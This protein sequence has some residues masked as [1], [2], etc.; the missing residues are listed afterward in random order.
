MVCPLGSV[1]ADTPTLPE[2][3]TE[4]KNGVRCPRPARQVATRAYPASGRGRTDL[5]SSTLKR[6]HPARALPSNPH[7]QAA[8]SVSHTAD[9]WAGSTPEI[10]A[11]SGFR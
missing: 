8:S 1:P 5:D 2:L 7:D 6:W 11:T 9:L 3:S 10:Q 4:Y